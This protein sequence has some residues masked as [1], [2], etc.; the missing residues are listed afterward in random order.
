MRTAG[1]QASEMRHVHMEIGTD[2]IGD[3]AE[4][5]EIDLARIGGAASDD[6]FRLVL[7]GQRLDL[8]K[9]NQRV[10]LAHAVLHRL[11]PFTGQVRRSAVRQVTASSQRQAHDRVARL[12][13]SQHDGLVR[14]RAGMRLHVCE[15]AVEQLAC[16]LDRQSF[17]LV[18]KFTAAVITAS[19]IAFRILVRQDRALCFQ[20][21]AGDNILGGNQLDLV[22]LP[23]QF[24]G[25]R[26]V[27]RGI[28]LRQRFGKERVIGC[29]RFKG[30]H[31]SSCSYPA[32]QRGLLA[33]TSQCKD[34]IYMLSAN[35]SLSTRR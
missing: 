28:T 26:A 20:H 17:R 3:L 16:A 18:D 9:V 19:R 30:G 5:L 10:F 8:I 23:L 7:L 35:P 4:P 29:A 27:K 32:M 22:F 24:L 11:E 14:L 13:Q 33:Q 21:R 31:D 34:V 25:D 12:D 6:Q 2:G 15:A 1:N